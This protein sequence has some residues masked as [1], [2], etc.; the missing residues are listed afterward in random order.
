MKS[1][2]HVLWRGAL[3]LAL[4]VVGVGSGISLPQPAPGADAQASACAGQATDAERVL[5]A[6]GRGRPAA[7]VNA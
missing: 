5:A 3:A 1:M 4:M 2:Q 7:P 6:G